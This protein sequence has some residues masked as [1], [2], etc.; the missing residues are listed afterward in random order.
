[1]N[2]SLHIRFPA[3]C[4]FLIMNDTKWCELLLDIYPDGE[5][6]SWAGNRIRLK[7]IF[8]GI[9]SYEV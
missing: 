2:I 3:E 6:R 7:K 5:V 4:E 8:P 1:M 9:D